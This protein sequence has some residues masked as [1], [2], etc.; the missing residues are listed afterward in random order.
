MMPRS[1]S[2]GAQ[3]RPLSHA[4]LRAHVASMLVAVC[5]VGT[6]LMVAGLLQLRGTVTRNLDLVARSMAFSAEAAVV[7][8]DGQATR[9]EIDRI[10]STE[11]VE[12]VVVT[13]AQGQVLAEWH[14]KKRDTASDALQWLSSSGL[15]NETV[16]VPVLSSGRRVGEIR[17]RGTPDSMWGFLVTGCLWILVCIG[18]SLAMTAYVTRRT[19]RLIMHPL[20][21]LTEVTRRVRTVRAFGERVPQADIVELNELANDF[22]SLLGELELWEAGVQ[23]ENRALAHQAAHDSLTGLPNRMAFENRL[24]QTMQRAH[25]DRHSFA[26]LFV[27]S[28]DFKSINDQFGHAAGDAVLVQVARRISGHLRASD[29]VARLGGDEFAILLDPVTDR[30]SAQRVA[31]SIR[32]TMTQPMALEQG[33]TLTTSISV[34][35]ALYPHDASDM[36][37]LLRHADAAMYS[38][39]ADHR[40]AA[41]PACGQQAYSESILIHAD[42]KKNA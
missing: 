26:V 40:N 33:V 31:E 5:C 37:A 23:G 10:A 3:P 13:D 36:A 38:D 16:S 19:F 11:D 30:E 15:L 24:R 18:A 32:A 2:G 34:G 21:M 17:A 42:S 14:K 29:M 39:K 6:A 20:R 25:A 7:F 22:N 35:A 9:S 1:T 27:D 4:L 12:S 28:N 8:H 41:V